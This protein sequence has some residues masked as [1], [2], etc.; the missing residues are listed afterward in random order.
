MRIGFI[1][2]VVYPFVTGGAQKRI[3]EI[4]K[5]LAAKDHDIT[6]Y[7]RHFWDGPSITTQQGM[8]LHAVAPGTKLY[9]DSG[10][11][12]I[13]EAID[14]SLRLLPQ[15]RQQVDNHDLLVI[16]VFPYFP[17]LSSELSTF[18]KDIPI[19][20]TW[21]EVW[22]DYWNDYLGYLA[23]FGKI[24]ERI[25][26]KVPQYPVAVS[27]VTA[28]RL[29]TVGPKRDRIEI[30][31]NGID[32]D[33]IQSISPVKGGDDVLFAG[34][35]IEDKNVDR[36]IQAFDNVAAEHNVTLRII[37]DGPQRK[38]LENQANNCRFSDQITFLGFLDEYEDVLAYMKAATIFI[39][40]ST[41]EG[42]GISYLEAMA[43]GCIVIGADHPESA[44]SEVINDAGFVVDPTMETLSKTL[45]DV[46]KGA[47][48][49]KDPK[50][51]VK[52]YD[53]DKISKHAEKVYQEAIAKH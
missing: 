48:P 6:I 12:S 8:T 50:A 52:K 11:R 30:V 51:T 15:T 20:T 40:P 28:N 1:S 43:A 10:R 18:L 9:T 32:L 37:G 16:S 19:I 26:A 22:K 25:T 49:E 2:N 38:K 29:S 27:S 35:L 21:H 46:L 39:S 13:V 44:A 45:E 17:V 41:R 36:L 34:R 42:F 23:P 47:R 31:P 3:Y 24:I 14:F 4:G 7:G 33:R 53:W 5:R